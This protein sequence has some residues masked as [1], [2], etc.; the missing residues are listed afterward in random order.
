MPS[1]SFSFQRSARSPSALFCRRCKN[2]FNTFLDSALSVRNM[3]AIPRKT[4]H[5]S[6]FRSAASCKYVRR[7]PY[8]WW[9]HGNM[10][11]N[12]S[13]C[14][15]PQESLPLPLPGGVY[16]FAQHWSG[17]CSIG[18]H[19]LIAH[20]RRKTQQCLFPTLPGSSSSTPYI[21]DL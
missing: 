2:L 5:Q 7:P 14:A 8:F 15:A 21:G 17:I 19:Y 6:L 20:G 9:N 18:Q 3:A 1:P 16:R 12:R 11:P 10:Q 4:V 13:T